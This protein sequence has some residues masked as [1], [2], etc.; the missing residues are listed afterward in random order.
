MLLVGAFIL[1]GMSP[2]CAETPEELQPLLGEP[3]AAP[4]V[5]S[6]EQVQQIVDETFKTALGFELKDKK[7]I[8][9]KSGKNTVI[10]FAESYNSQKKIAFEW[11]GKSEY[12]DGKNNYSKTISPAEMKWIDHYQFDHTYIVVSYGI[13]KESIQYDISKFIEFY[14]NR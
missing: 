10:F 12:H 4:K 8:S 3:V 1:A 2:L 7:E 6:S 14:T 11:M 9:L 5:L 13:N